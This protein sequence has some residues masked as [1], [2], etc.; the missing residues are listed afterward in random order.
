MLARYIERAG[1]NKNI[2][3]HTLRHAF[4]TDLYRE[5]GKI[6]LV[7]KVLGHANLSATMVSAHIFDEEVERALKSFRQ[8]TA[9]AV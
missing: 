7:Q 6:R 3:P 1:I 9:V 8:A 4:A 2:S 5:T